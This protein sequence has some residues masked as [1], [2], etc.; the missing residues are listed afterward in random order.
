MAT[1]WGIISVG[2]ISCD[3]AAAVQLL[4]KEEHQ[5]VAVAARS[6]QDAKN[7][8]AKY[9]IEKAY[10][11]Y[12]EMAKDPNVD[13]VYIGTTHICHLPVSSQMLKAGKPVL[14]E[15]PLCMNVRETQ[16]LVQTARECGVFLMEAVFSRF[17]PA[18]KELSRRLQDGEIGEVVQVIASLGKNL[19]HLDKLK[20]IQVDWS[21]GQEV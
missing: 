8:A 4:P 16:Q 18:Y 5:V 15:K 1:R 21:I 10:G 3:F 19:I 7:F 11:S 13:V 12:S 17:F 14:C 20:F 2:M 6:L 9:G